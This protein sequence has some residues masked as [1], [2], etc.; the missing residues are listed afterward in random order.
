MGPSMLRQVA[1]ICAVSLA[2]ATGIVPR[3]GLGAHEPVNALAHSASPYL[4]LHA[5]DPG[6]LAGVEPGARRA[7][8]LRG[9]ADLRLRRLLRLPLVHVMQRESFSDRE[10]AALLNAHF[11]SV[12]VDREL[13]PA[14]DAQLLRFVQATLG[15]AGWPLNVVLT[16]DGVPLFGFTYLPAADFKR[17]L[18]QIV[19]RWQVDRD[20]AR[21]GGAHCLGHARKRRSPARGGSHG[22]RRRARAERCVHQQASEIG[23]RARGGFGQQQ[24]FPSAPQLALLL[25]SQRRQPVDALAGFLRLTF[26]AM[27]SLGLR[28]QIG[29]GFFRYVTDP[30][31]AVP[32]FEKMLYDNA[33]LAE[34]YFDAADVLASGLRTGRDGHRGF[35]GARARIPA[36]R[37]VFEPV[38][39]RCG[40]RG[41]RLLPVRLR[42]TWSA[43]LDDEERRVA[44]AAAWGSTGTPRS[45]TDT[46]RPGR[47]VGRGGGAR[48][49]PVGRGDG[50]AARL[51][52]EEAAG[53]ARRAGASAR[54]EA[55]RGVERPRALDAGARI[56]APWRRA[57]R[58]T[59][60][61]RGALARRRALGRDRRSCGR[62]PTGERGPRAD[63]PSVTPA[64]LQDY[65]Y[66][67]R[68]MIAF[69]KAHGGQEHWDIART[70]VEGAWKR[71]RT[72]TAGACPT[73]AGFPTPAWN[74]PSRTD[75]C[76]RLRRCCSTPRCTSRT[77]ST[78]MRSVRGRAPRCSPTR[79]ACAPPRSSTQPESVTLLQWRLDRAR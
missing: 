68:G 64:T 17:L 70:I 3:V 56:A 13:D 14:L 21:G 76:L 1:G 69:A 7:G 27:A 58:G 57:V 34:L 5:G 41:G 22:R 35:H 10:A 9:P 60:P 79:P 48:R 75:R 18:E 78:T 62:G 54:R 42:K 53:G 24:K 11:L 40:R 74:P 65:A 46:C 37:V 23:R 44:G 59:G 73:L 39:G 43:V 2:L 52:A 45:S 71:F 30:G 72:P 51:G 4:R 28:D 50:G 67:A 19:S 55:S 29:G 32:H 36:R 66:V 16:P 25:D 6:A 12:K 33:L 15:H 31:W 8:R 38:R 63:A 77:V 26:G 61:R 49:R 47:G 20:S